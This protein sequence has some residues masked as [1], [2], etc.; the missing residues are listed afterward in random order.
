M[1]EDFSALR[2][3]LL[4]SDNP[5]V[6]AL[7]TD[8]DKAAEIYERDGEPDNSQDQCQLARDLGIGDEWVVDRWR[9]GKNRRN[10]KE[11]AEAKANAFPTKKS[12]GVPNYPRRLVDLKP[13]AQPTN[14]L[15]QRAAENRKARLAV[16]AA[17]PA[18]EPEE[19]PTTDPEEGWVIPPLLKPPV[20]NKKNP[21]QAA[22][23]FAANMLTYQRGDERVLGTWF[24]NN[25]WLQWNGSAY[26]Y[27]SDQRL[28]DMMANYLDAAKVQSGDYGL[29]AYRP[30]GKQVNETAKFLRTC[31][32][33]EE[34]PPTWLPGYEGGA[35]PKELLAFRNCVLNV[36]TGETFGHDPELLVT[37]ALGYDYN[38][39]ARCDLWRWFLDDILPQDGDAQMAVEEWLGYCMT[40][41]N[42]FEKIALWVGEPRSGRGTIARVLE[43]LV[44]NN[45]HVP[46]NIHNWNRGENS[47]EGMIGKKVGIFHDVRL[48]E[49]KQFGAAGLDPGGLTENSVQDLL[50]FSSGDA[51]SMKRMYEAAQNERPEI[52]LTVIT[53]K[54]LNVRDPVLLTRFYLQWFGQSRLDRED[55]LLKK[56][57]LPAEKAGI[58]WRSQVAYR[59]LLA[60]DRML[61]PASGLVL[62]SQLREAQLPQ[63]KFM[64]RYWQLDPERK[65][66]WVRV[67]VFNAVFKYWARAEGLL[68]WTTTNENG[69]K[70]LVRE[71]KEWRCLEWTRH[72]SEPRK[73][74]LVL[75]LGSVSEEMASTIK[76]MEDGKWE[77]C[78]ELIQA[79]MRDHEAFVTPLATAWPKGHSR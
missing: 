73:Y 13:K 3:R 16:V 20:L 48:K 70:K 56:V 38:E 60:R 14:E 53:N 55:K 78:F 64:N 39:K 21:L 74:P 61:E 69:I 25:R 2:L 19:E 59:R 34:G 49:P 51:T 54:I 57:K 7:V 33:L 47:K 46:L 32:A 43:E 24:H 12:E 26:E 41:D 35:D 31:T 45:H 62:V 23:S 28:W 6:R 15:V 76:V 29:A 63:L 58:G 79:K 50:E 10:E 66:D 8:V 11:L 77:L 1:R 22:R 30:E 4:N 40:W 27:A 68:H 71:I 5:K 37:D 75:K 67:S 72:N 44:G 18:A 65:A 52:K 36:R 42:R 17:E 9:R